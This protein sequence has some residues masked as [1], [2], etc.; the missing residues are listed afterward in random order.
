MTRN[1]LDMMMIGGEAALAS[2]ENETI[3][4]R[5]GMLEKQQEVACH[6]TLQSIIIS[7]PMLEH[8]Q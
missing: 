7:L 8:S 5:L 6:R 2:I 3:T 4:I 1:G